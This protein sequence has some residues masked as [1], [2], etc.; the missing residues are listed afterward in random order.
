[1]NRQSDIPLNQNGIN[2]AELAAKRLNNLHFDCIYSSDLIRA[3]VTAE[4]AAAGRNI[5][6]TAQLREWFFGK[7]QD[8]T[9]PEIEKLF[10]E[11]LKKYRSLDPSFCP[12]DGES[13]Q[14]F[15]QRSADFMQMLA[16][17]HKNQTVLCVSHGGFIRTVLQNALQ[18]E[19]FSVYPRMD[20]TAVSCFKTSNNGKSWQLV[21]WNDTSHLN[22][23]STENQ[24]AL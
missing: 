2:Q 18:I 3:K 15:R 5:I 4:Y 11:N 9:F 10:P 22:S 17:K 19:R 8:K 14:L 20:N 6:Y 12:D 1:M 23:G 13:N 16:E 21:L 7:W 24:S